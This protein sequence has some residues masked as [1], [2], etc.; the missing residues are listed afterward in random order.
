PK[1]KNSPDGPIYH[2]SQLLYG[3]N[4][5]KAE[6]VAREQVVICE[7][8]TDVMAFA[9]AG[10]PNAVATCGTALADDHFRILKN[11]TRR[12]VLAYDSDSAGQGAA[13]R[14]YGWE[15]QFD[16]EVRVADL[17]AGRDP[18]DVWHDDPAALLRSLDGAEP[19]LAF[20]ID[21]ALAAADRTTI[22]GR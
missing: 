21:R 2:K 16:I 5:A 14:W 9:L 4:W 13:E 1:Y 10:A 19:F 17:P 6:I 3:L 18:A 8:Y 11:L 15:Q 12:I 20:R 7:G 22:E